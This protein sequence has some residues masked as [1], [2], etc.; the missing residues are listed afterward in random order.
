MLLRIRRIG[1]GMEKYDRERYGPV[2]GSVWFDGIRL[3]ER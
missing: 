2:A 3:I 1:S